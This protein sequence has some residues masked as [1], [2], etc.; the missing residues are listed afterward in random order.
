M[1]Y[2]YNYL[3]KK[4]PALQKKIN[5]VCNEKREELNNA[6]ELY[7][8]PEMRKFYYQSKLDYIKDMY[9]DPKNSEEYKKYLSKLNSL[10]A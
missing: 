9:S 2:L 8:L 5:D 4:I 3:D 7:Q 6:K 10:S 1:G